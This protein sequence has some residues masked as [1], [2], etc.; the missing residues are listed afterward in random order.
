MRVDE[1]L[2][3]VTVGDTCGEW[4]RFRGKMDFVLMNPPY[5]RIHNLSDKPGS[6]YVTGMCDLYYAFFDYAQRMLAPG[7][8]LSAIAPS[9]W[10]TSAAGAAMRDDLRSRGVVRAVCDYGHLQVFA[11]CATTYTA[12]VL[13][14]TGR[15]ATVDVWGH[16]AD[17]SLGERETV[18]SASCWHGGLFLPGAPAG[19]DEML[20][21]EPG[22][23][24]VCVR[25]GY[26][27]NLDRLFMSG[28]RR[29]SAYEIPVVKAS[30]AR[31]M[32]AVY[33]YGRDGSLASLDEIG[34]A[35]PALADAL[36]GEREALLARTQVD[37]ARWW[38]YARTQGLA[39]TWVDK[40]AVQSLVLPPT[41]PRTCDAPAG[42]G[43]FGGVYV[44][45]MA[46]AEVDEAVSSEEFFGYVRALR[47][48]KSGGYYAYG[49]R[50]L[51][52]FLS[53]W[54][55]QRGAIRA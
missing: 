23:H 31:R 8:A 18:G 30:R 2:W 9:S 46:R 14:G 53:W 27:T 7:G 40:V 45:G 37:P 50:D 54:R 24:G 1:A 33:P 3:D 17:G 16:G 12:L 48:Y 55:A 43:V 22:S 15:A 35:D 19:M 52:R 25:N 38:C 20:A 13:I 4:G 49:G 41:P 10:M 51:G 47:K 28:S 39:D 36:E 11:P 6:S 5:V 29:F 21:T 44:T 26:A 42:T 32:F 34:A